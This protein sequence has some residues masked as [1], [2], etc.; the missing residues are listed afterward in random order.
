MKGS[1]CVQEDIVQVPEQSW[2]MFQPEPRAR[3]LLLFIHPP[4]HL[5][6]R[7][8]SRRCF[9]HLF[10]VFCVTC[11]ETLPSWGVLGPS[12][13]LLLYHLTDRRPQIAGLCLCWE[14]AWS[15]NSS[16]SGEAKTVPATVRWQLLP[17]E[18]RRDNSGKAYKSCWR[19]KL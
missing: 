7:P 18:R 13:G 14:P 8:S 19:A 17:G 10:S 6:E 3:L 16:F 2:W 1:A 15:F 5:P 11:P 12:L 9:P 4:H